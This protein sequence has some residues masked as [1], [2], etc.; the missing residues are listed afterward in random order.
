MKYTILI[1]TSL[2]ISLVSGTVFAGYSGYVNIKRIRIDTIYAYIG[3]DSQPANT[4]SNFG[5][6]FKFDNKTEAGKAFLSTL[7]TAK[8][9][10]KLVEIWYSDSTVLGSNQDNGC[11]DS[12]LSN[13]SGVSIP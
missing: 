6:Y 4:C 10:G 1:A 3:T 2:V 12:T 11:N 7:L 5:E 8:A 13:L 9:S